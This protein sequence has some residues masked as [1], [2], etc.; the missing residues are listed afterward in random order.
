MDRRPL[1]PAGA[2]RDR[3]I[4]VDGDMFH[5]ST[6]LF[7]AEGLKHRRCAPQ[8]QSRKTLGAG[9]APCRRVRRSPHPGGSGGS[10]SRNRVAC[11]SHTFASPWPAGSMSTLAR[12]EKSSRP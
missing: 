11:S 3:L 1:L 6:P 10:D 8:A 4:D 9:P 2:V 5:V 12:A 7:A